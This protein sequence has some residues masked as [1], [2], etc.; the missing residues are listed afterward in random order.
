MTDSDRSAP[1]GH[2]TVTAFKLRHEQE[3]TGTSPTRARNTPAHRQSRPQ[4]SPL[5]R[6]I[7]LRVGLFRAR[8][9]YYQP[10][11]VMTQR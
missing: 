8:P 5:P 6:P 7:A 3:H 10:L 1:L 11:R 9:A 4:A 2:T